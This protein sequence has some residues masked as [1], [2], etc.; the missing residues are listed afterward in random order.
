MKTWR[1]P[2]LGEIG[3]IRL[4]DQPRKVWGHLY[5]PSERWDELSPSDIEQ[6]KAQVVTLFDVIPGRRKDLPNVT[7]QVRPE[8]EALL[9]SH[10]DEGFEPAYRAEMSSAE[11][12]WTPTDDSLER[13]RVLTPRSV[14]AVVARDGLVRRTVTAFRPTPRYRSVKWD[15]GDRRRYA[16]DYFGR[17]TRM[18]V[19]DVASAVVADLKRCVE[20]PRDSKGLWWLASAVGQGRLLRE[21]EEVRV[22]LEPAERLLAAVEPGLVKELASGLEWDKL[23]DEL[24]SALKEE[25]PEDF[26]G[27][28]ADVESV[29]AVA[30][31]LGVEGEAK[32]FLEQADRLIPWVPLE[33]GHLLE[34][35]RSRLDGFEARAPAARLWGAVAEALVSASVRAEEPTIRPVSRLVDRLIP[36]GPESLIERIVLFA[37]VARAGASL[38]RPIHSALQSLRVAAPVPQMGGKEEPEVVAEV[39]GGELD[40]PPHVRVFVIDEQYP[41]GLEVTESAREAGAPLWQFEREDESAWVVVVAGEEPLQGGDLAALVEEAEHREDV[42]IAARE[43]Q[44]TQATKERR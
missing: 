19:D 24:A 43:L 34:V 37:L 22:V 2:E 25:R 32:A 17:Q 14:F 33:W 29:L 36:A 27:W 26:E 18:R 44:P 6:M 21:R 42:V 4:E 15:E 11:A 40:W 20:V 12:M 16:E 23:E 13:R 38:Y 3:P 41:A 28:L 30:D 31:A 1:H 5:W 9:S 7:S 10:H 8:L 35:A 39:L